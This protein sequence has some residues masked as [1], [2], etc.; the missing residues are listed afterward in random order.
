MTWAA[1]AA[2]LLAVFGPLLS[3]LLQKWLDDLL[4]RAVKRT[5]VRPDAYATAATRRSV[6]MDAA[7]EQ[8]DEDGKALWIW[9]KLPWS[10]HSR[11]RRLL[12]RMCDACDQDVPSP[13]D[14]AAIRELAKAAE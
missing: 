7:I 14:K 3:D 11:R 8:H 5:L 1:I 13:D 4:K 9:Q 12:V 2:A 10:Q 6:L